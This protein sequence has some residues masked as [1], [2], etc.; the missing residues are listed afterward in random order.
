MNTELLLRVADHIEA[1]PE[2]FDLGWWAAP[3]TE[4]NHPENVCDTV[5]CVAGWAAMLADPLLRV[6]IASGEIDPDLI[7]FSPE[8]RKHLEIDDQEADTLFVS[9]RWWAHMMK[10]FGFESDGLSRDE[11]WVSLEDV[12]AKAA[13][14]I[15]RELAQGNIS[16]AGDWDGDDD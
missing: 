5:G 7:E 10:C 6:S 9:N 3:T 15:L 16:L 12:P 11:D 13:A 1:F 8:A 4:S 2:S 14:H